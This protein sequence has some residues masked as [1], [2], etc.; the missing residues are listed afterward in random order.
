MQFTRFAFVA[1]VTLCKL[2]IFAS[3]APVPEWSSL[4]YREALPEPVCPAHSANPHL[5]PTTTEFYHATRLLDQNQPN[6][7]SILT[8][9]QSS[10]SPIS[11]EIPSFLIPNPK[12]IRFVF[13]TLALYLATY[14]H[15]SRLPDRTLFASGSVS[16]FAYSI[17]ILHIPSSAPAK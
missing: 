10:P 1:V 9:V 3:A 12:V 4:E 17:P 16:P 5:Q 2:S 6:F 11:F 14:S 7:K 13:D 8:L 15:R